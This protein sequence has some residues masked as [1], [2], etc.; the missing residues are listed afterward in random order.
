MD[1]DDDDDEDGE[2]DDALE[3]IDE[4]DEDDDDDD[5]EDEE[6]GEVTKIWLFLL[7]LFDAK[8]KLS[9]FNL[10]HHIAFSQVFRIIKCIAWAFSLD[11]KSR[12]RTF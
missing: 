7:R 5:D 1:E 4:E 2:E 9:P 3:D 10:I 8:S 12:K 6:D 11:G